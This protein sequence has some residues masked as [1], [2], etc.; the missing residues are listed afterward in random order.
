MATAQELW[1]RAKP[2]VRRR[3]SFTPDLWRSVEAAVPVT[4]DGTTF[5][6]GLAPENENLR[7]YLET[8][9]MMALLR[10]ILR[11]L[12]GEAMEVVIIMGTTEEDWQRHKIRQEQVRRLTSRTAEV[13]TRK[14]KERDWSWFIHQLDH[15]HARLSHRQYDFVKAG[16]LLDCA[17]K[18]AEFAL[19][20][21][22]HHPDRKDEVTRELE[23]VCQRLAGMLNAPAIVVGMEIERALRERQKESK[24]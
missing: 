4:I 18:A 12:T 2:L 16:F 23:R 6:L 11:E 5:V 3:M 7:G 10:E 20:Y 22:A 24:E 21:L 14:A 19:D 15:D 1:E 13:T 8:P 17:Q 9:T